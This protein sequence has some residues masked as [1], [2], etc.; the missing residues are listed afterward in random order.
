MI[1]RPIPELSCVDVLILSSEPV[2]SNG[3]GRVSGPGGSG[4]RGERVIGDGMV[5]VSQILSVEPSEA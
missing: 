1:H 4:G 5:H 2:V 3:A